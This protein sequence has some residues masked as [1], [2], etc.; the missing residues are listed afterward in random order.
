MTAGGI[1]REAYI[2]VKDQPDRREGCPAER[3]GKPAA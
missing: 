1:Y 3:E 2:P